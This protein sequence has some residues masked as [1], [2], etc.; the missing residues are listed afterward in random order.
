MIKNIAGT[1]YKEIP[2]LANS[3]DKSNNLDCSFARNTKAINHGDK[4]YGEI[5]K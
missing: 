4:R 2:A 1:K 3:K 5:N